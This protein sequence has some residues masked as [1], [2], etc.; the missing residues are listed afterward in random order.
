VIVVIVCT[1]ILAMLMVTYLL[2]RGGRWS[3]RDAIP[4]RHLPS[5]LQRQELDRLAFQHR[6]RTRAI[7]DSALHN[8]QKAAGEHRNGR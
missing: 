6:V 5:E 1:G 8:I 3:Q 2:A 7:L 4:P